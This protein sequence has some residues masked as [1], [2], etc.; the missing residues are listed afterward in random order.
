MAL[1]SLILFSYTPML[2]S[3]EARPE[4]VRIRPVLLLISHNLYFFVRTIQSFTATFYKDEPRSAPP[5]QITTMHS[6][7]LHPRSIYSLVQLI[8]LAYHKPSLPSPWQYVD[9][10]I[11]ALCRHAC[12]SVAVPR[13]I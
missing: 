3:I 5:D 10:F 9:I 4:A 1:H 13:L 2:V 11:R 12:L 7:L 6:L 8:S